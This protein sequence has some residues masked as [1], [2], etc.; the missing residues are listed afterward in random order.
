[1]EKKLVKACELRIELQKMYLNGEKEAEKCKELNR[2][3]YYTLMEWAN[4]YV[5]KNF[6]K[7]ADLK[8]VDDL[9][10][11]HMD[12]LN[13]VVLEKEKELRSKK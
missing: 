2:Q 3:Y 13:I 12:E 11:E 5:I 6:M 1:M 4:D 7:S 10:K 9:I 8:T